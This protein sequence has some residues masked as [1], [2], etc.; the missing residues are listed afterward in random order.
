MDK[1]RVLF[2]VLISL[3]LIPGI[4]AADENPPI[5][6]QNGATKLSEF[7]SLENLDKWIPDFL[8]N[9]LNSWKAGKADEAFTKALIFV[10]ISLFVYSILDMAGFFKNKLVVL[11]IS[12]AVGL[13]ST[14]YMTKEFIE[15]IGGVY[16]A[17]GGAIVSIVPFLV[18]TLFTI[19]VIKKNEE[20]GIFLQNIA[21][22]IFS[23]FLIYVYF[24]KGRSLIVLFMFFI[25]LIM[26][27]LNAKFVEWIFNKTEWMK[28]LT[29]K[30]KA[31]QAARGVKAAQTLGETLESQG[32]EGPFV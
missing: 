18:I 31:N 19:N 30:A 11:G 16:T 6:T 24:T 22:G 14:M 15:E 20:K 10:I 17:F 21:W 7:F 2:F 1:K 8:E 32:D 12:F 25:S 13:L 27:I 28:N 23:F 4:F 5:I 29:A 9:T 26:T 3:I